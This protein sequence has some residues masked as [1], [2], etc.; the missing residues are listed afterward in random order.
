MRKL[1]TRPEAE[2]VQIEVF[3]K[4]KPEARLKLSLQLSET[5][6]EFLKEG[7]RTRHP[8]YSR[9]EVELALK[10]ILLGERLFKLV[11]PE[12]KDIKP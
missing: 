3:R 9:Q 8:Q 7:I 2:K 6:K 10:R 4:M 1:D 11:Y 5:T 12:A